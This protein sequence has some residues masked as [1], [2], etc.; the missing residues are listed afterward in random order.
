MDLFV[1]SSRKEGY[2]TT[3]T[4]SIIVGTRV[5]TTDCSGMDEILEDSGA[6]I[7]VENNEEALYL[8]LKD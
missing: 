3:I 1:C 2:S 4:E 6:G 8:G 7:I 5:I